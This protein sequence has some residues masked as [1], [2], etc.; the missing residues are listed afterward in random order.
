M[1]EL[2]VLADPNRALCGDTPEQFLRNLE[3]PACLLLPGMNR[4]RSRAFVTLLHGNEPSG[5]LALRRWLLS[6]QQPAVN[7]VAVVA[8]V[9]A[10]LAQPVFSQRMRRGARDLN[11]CFRP[12]W[13]DGPGQ[14]ARNIIDVLD[15][16]AVEAVVDMHNTSGAGPD[17]GVVSHDDPRHDALLSLFTRR[18]VVSGLNLGALMELSSESRPI[19][20]AEVGGRLDA[21]AHEI[22]WQGL[23]RYFL[24]DLPLSPQGTGDMEV[25][26]HPVRL[27]LRE[28]VTLGYGDHG[29]SGCDVTLRPDIESFNF[30][31]VDED[32]CLGWA[33]ARPE[34][35]FQALDASGRCKART[36]LRASGGSLYPARPLKLFMITNSAAIAQA[37][38]LCYAVGADGESLQSVA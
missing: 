30:G 29:Q 21:S 12:P 20:T 22:A 14:L 19:V 26:R 31:S 4:N 34:Q 37:D 11:R 6:G 2:R 24:A 33:S 5:L 15:A 38:C 36:L 35:L 9:H 8:S 23:Q 25:F 27:E 16:Q 10:A 17:F 28:G 18:L 1:S 13:D 7:I 32:T 3:G